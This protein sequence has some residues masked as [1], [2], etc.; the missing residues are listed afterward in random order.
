MT[1][2]TTKTTFPKKKLN[3]KFAF[4][5]TS[6]TGV[7]A[8]RSASAVKLLVAKTT[9]VSVESFEHLKTKPRMDHP[10]FRKCS[11]RRFSHQKRSCVR[12]KFFSICRTTLPSE[13]DFANFLFWLEDHLFRP[14][15]GHGHKAGLSPC[16]QQWSIDQK[17]PRRITIKRQKEEILKGNST[18]KKVLMFKSG[19]DCS[20]NFW[21]A[22]LKSDVLWNTSYCDILQSCVLVFGEDVNDPQFF[23]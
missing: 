19:L 12:S 1:R 21:V 3:S 17:Y 13:D 8:W 11:F 22:A 18:G 15:K 9:E 20:V 5:R 16:Q 10:I 4:W 2:T 14:N 23:I 6:E 7:F